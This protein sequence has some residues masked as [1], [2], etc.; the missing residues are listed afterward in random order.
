MDEVFN[1]ASNS[2]FP[3]LP[4]CHG[5]LELPEECQMG[6]GP[7]TKAEQYLQGIKAFSFTKWQVVLGVF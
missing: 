5:H 1:K 4:E 2:H 6:K 3:Q 7:G